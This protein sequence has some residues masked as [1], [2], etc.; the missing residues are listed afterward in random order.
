M[1]DA[2][3][4]RRAFRAHHHPAEVALVEAHQLGEHML[5]FGGRQ[6]GEARAAAGGNEEVG[7]ER[8]RT[9]RG[10]PR[11]EALQLP[12][13]TLGDRRLD[14]EVHAM[15]AESADRG[16]SGLEGAVT[17]A[18]VVVVLGRQGVDAHG[19]AGDAGA[20]ERLDAPIVEERSV[21]ADDDRRA[22]MRGVLGE[23]L[24]IG[25]QQRLAAGE[26]EQGRWIDREYLAR[27]AETLAR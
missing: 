8:Y 9:L 20:L 1:Y 11:H 13:V 6:V 3:E 14:D 24:E 26:N 12:A 27:D 2:H 25:A 7:V 15:R 21:R 18:E 19:E 4:V 23:A 5:I 22:V 17:A 10:S 16:G